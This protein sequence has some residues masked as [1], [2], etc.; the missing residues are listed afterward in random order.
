M[1]LKWQRIWVVQETV[2]AKKATIYYGQLSAP[3]TMFSHA[4]IGYDKT[5]LLR[6]A[7]SVYP[8]LYNGQPLMHFSRIVIEI[9]STRRLW[10]KVQP[11]TL[12]PLLR[13]FRARHATD[14][15]DK[16]FALLGLVRHWAGVD[17]II[18]DYGME[19]SQVFRE[20]TI[21]A[22]QA[23][24][25]LSILAGTLQ[26]DSMQWADHP[27][28]VADFAS[29]PDVHENIRVDNSSLYNAS[30]GL[31]GTVRV[32]GVSIL[33]TNGIHI[34]DIAFVG[35]QLPLS[36]DGHNSR[37]RLS[38]SEWEKTL[39]QLGTS[40]YIAGGTIAD[41]FWRLICGDVEH[42][43]DAGGKYDEAKV[44]FRRAKASVWSTYE[45]WRWAGYSANRR[46]S[47]IAGYWKEVDDEE[48]I[49][50]MMNAF[51]HAVEC[52]SGLRRIFITSRGYIGTG[53]DE[54]KV[55]DDIFTLYGSRVPFVLR[56]VDYATICASAPV[57]ELFGVGND[58]RGRIDLTKPGD[59]KLELK[60]LETICHETHHESYRV[61]GDAYVHGIMDG[62]VTMTKGRSCGFVPKSVFLV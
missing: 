11:T 6:N 19:A 13:K 40:D 62:E 14:G 29:P 53:P 46:T 5:H 59:K 15:R 23:T 17:R 31:S 20:T 50:K 41:A 21:T 60:V 36:A 3:W 39:S 25:S 8:Y 26:R 28:W 38:V 32:H 22:I 24:K 47:I 55:G 54:I 45:Q 42:C 49:S 16:V 4:A 7:D 37:L 48:G 18:P 30:K 57:R 35:Q 1:R 2:V 34:D 12:L 43:K 51:H 10:L 33:E 56:S 61:V 9:E 58:G 44:E 52:A 27:S